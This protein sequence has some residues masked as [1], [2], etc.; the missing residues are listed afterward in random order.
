[1]VTAMKE[2][3]LIGAVLCAFIS[4]VFLG[5]QLIV[6]DFDGVKYA[7]FMMVSGIALRNGWKDLK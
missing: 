2:I 4:L 5:L 1:M 7:T 3:C 6:R